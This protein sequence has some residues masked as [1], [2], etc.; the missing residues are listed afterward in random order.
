MLA[1]SSHVDLLA[2]SV[3]PSHAGLV[4]N[5]VVATHQTAKQMQSSP[6]AAPTPSSQPPF[7][8]VD[9]ENLNPQL[10][11]HLSRHDG[12]GCHRLTGTS[13]QNDASK[14][15]HDATGATVA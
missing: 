11:L 12:G 3:G 4:T 7:T 6:I 10:G 2:N 1:T 5:F 8:A 15:E 13:F 9:I 14:E